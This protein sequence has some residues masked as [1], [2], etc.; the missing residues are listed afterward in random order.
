MILS[1]LYLFVC[2]ADKSAFDNVSALV[3]LGL[4]FLIIGVGFI[5]TKK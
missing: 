4:D 1:L 2:I 5:A 3:L